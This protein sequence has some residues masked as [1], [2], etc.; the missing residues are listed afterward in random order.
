MEQ[1]H[2]K[3]GSHGALSKQSQGLDKKGGAWPS[4][5][6]PEGR[7][8]SLNTSWNPAGS[9][10]NDTRFSDHEVTTQS[11]AVYICLKAPK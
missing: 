4:Q 1:P 10:T 11:V 3:G 9:K 2:S 8:F 5:R 6:E 7:M